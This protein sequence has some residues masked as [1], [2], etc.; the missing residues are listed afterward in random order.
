MQHSL[1]MDIGVGWHKGITRKYMPNEDSLAVL[2]GTCICNEQLVPFG[3]FIIADG[4]GGHSFGREASRIAIQQMTQAVLQ[5]LLKS[6][7]LNDELLGAMLVESV[8]LANR[9]I[10]QWSQLKGYNVGTTVTAALV[11]AGKAYVVNVGDSRTYRHDPQSGLL[12]I[13]CDHSLVASLVAAGAI[14]REEM[15][16]H[17]DRNKIYRCLGDENSLDV[18]RFIIDLRSGD[19]LLLCSDGLWEMVRDQHIERIVCRNIDLT[20]SS[21][22]LVEAALKGG[23]GDNVSAILVRMR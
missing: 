8:E 10:Y 22:E 3:L 16:T 19:T 17:P 1:H 23:G 18:D 7:Q 14:T 11:I 20:R 2:Q 15:Y 6:D 13:T 9:A 4:M 12:Q 21:N 5:N